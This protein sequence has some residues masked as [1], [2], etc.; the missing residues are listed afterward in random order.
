[1]VPEL[2]PEDHRELP[3]WQ[4]AQAEYLAQDDDPDQRFIRSVRGACRM[5]EIEKAHHAEKETR[6]GT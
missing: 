6:N 2:I 4:A 5:L 3:E 1:M